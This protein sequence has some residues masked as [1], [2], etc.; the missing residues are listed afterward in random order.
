MNRGIVNDGSKL[1]D[2]KY[3][4]VGTAD[5]LGKSSFAYGRGGGGLWISEPDFSYKV[6]LLIL[7]VVFF[8][9]FDNWYSECFLSNGDESSANAGLGARPG[10]FYNGDVVSEWPIHIKFDCLYYEYFIQFPTWPDHFC[11]HPSKWS[12]GYQM[13]ACIFLITPVKCYMQQML[14][15]KVICKNVA[16]VRYNHPKLW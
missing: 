1:P 15:V 8:S 7:S 2:P 11:I 13:K 10:T 16:K 9:E 3:M 5:L 4:I 14:L 12:F 6:Y